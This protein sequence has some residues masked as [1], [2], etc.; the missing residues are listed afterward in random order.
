LED[1]IFQ[2]LSRIPH[3]HVYRKKD[4]PPEYHYTNN[5]RIPAIILEPEE[6]YWISYNGSAGVSK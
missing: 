5:R 3:A 1:E 2:N 4:I 6:H